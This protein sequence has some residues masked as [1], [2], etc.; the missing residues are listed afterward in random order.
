MHMLTGL[1]GLRTGYN[2]GFL[3]D[4]MKIR[5][6]SEI[7]SFDEQINISFSTRFWA[8]NLVIKCGRIS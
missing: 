6:L 1:Q 7:G 4:I 3:H 5:V 2:D 8:N